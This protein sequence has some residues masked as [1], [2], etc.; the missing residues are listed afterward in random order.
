MVLKKQ[1]GLLAH[2]HCF[3][4]PSHIAHTVAVAASSHLQW[5]DRVGFTPTSLLSLKNERHPFFI[6]V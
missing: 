4:A 5:R 1:A 2:D 3:S 6:Y